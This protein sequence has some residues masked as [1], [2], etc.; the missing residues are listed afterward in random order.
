VLTAM[1]ERMPES[2]YALDRRAGITFVLAMSGDVAS[3]APTALRKGANDSIHLRDTLLPR[4]RT[5]EAG[6]LLARA[7]EC[8]VLAGDHEHALRILDSATEAELEHAEVRT[9]FAQANIHGGRPDRALV[10]LDDESAWTDDDRLVAAHALAHS[11]D[12]GPR[13]RATELARP[14]LDQADRAAS[15]ALALVLAAAFA[16]DLPW[17][18]DA[19]EIL[20]QT[21]PAAAA[22]LHAERLT[23]EGRQDEADRLLQQHAHDPHVLRALVERALDA[24]NWRRGLALAERLVQDHAQAE[25]R[26]LLARALK[27]GNKTDRLKQELN[28]LAG[29]SAQSEAIRGRAFAGLSAEL[30]PDDYA[31]LN[32]LTER[33]RRELPADTEGQWQ[34]T[35]ALARLGR[36]EAALTLIDDNKL[37]ATTVNHARLLA[38]TFLRVLKPLDAAR[39]IAELSDQFD[40]REESLEGLLLFTAMRVRE[41][42]GEPLR[43]RLA[44]TF[45]TF[46]ER[47]PDSTAIRTFSVDPE[48]PASLLDLIRSQFRPEHDQDLRDA[49][50][51]IANA[52]APLAYLAAMTSGHIPQIMQRISQI[53]LAYGHHEEWSR[54]LELARTALGGPA[55]WDPTSLTIVAAMPEVLQRA[56]IDALPASALAYSS[57]RECDTADAALDDRNE[58]KAVVPQGDGFRVDIVGEEQLAHE[59]SIINGAFIL[60]RELTTVADVD[61]DEP[62]EMDAFFNDEDRR[63][64]LATL[65]ATISVARRRG[66]PIYSDDRY[67]RQMAHRERIETFGTLTLLSALVERQHVGPDPVAQFRLELLRRGAVGLRPSGAEIAALADEVEDQ[68]LGPWTAMLMDPS[69]WRND[70]DE[71][72]RQCVVFLRHVWRRRPAL[73]PEW[74][75]RVLDCADRA[76]P[77]NHEFF[78]QIALIYLW[79]LIEGDPDERTQR[80]FVSA[81]LEAFAEAPAKLGIRPFEDLVGTALVRA[82]GLIRQTNQSIRRSMLISAVRQLPFPHDAQVL[83]TLWNHV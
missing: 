26:M 61:V 28:T 48:D 62:D 30:P 8:F 24:G 66:L 2:M 69:G 15:A 58:E 45:Q 80:R 60:A 12:L 22:H 55:V 65:P 38:A 36:Y 77:Q 25:D 78:A 49:L 19:G 39:R 56:V 53:P 10:I 9:D 42:A 7:A 63:S 59:H 5:L 76:L 74:V 79:F 23:R 52:S 21:A 14:L 16:V 41:D 71:H 81:L 67:V 72:L 40:R 51:Q 20:A 46:G 44:E 43:A 35:Y 1:V 27:D 6:R 37:T 34:R 13:Q 57:L 73:F 54:E 75:A 47:F 11:D 33:W 31:A 4:G 18:S 83:L 50:N 68:P 29:D 17:P 3:R 70:A 32:E 82:L 64:H